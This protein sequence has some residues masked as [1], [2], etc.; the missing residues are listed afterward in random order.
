MKGSKHL[1]PTFLAAL[2]FLNAF[3]QLSVAQQAKRSKVKPFAGIP[4]HE[5]L[6]VIKNDY[7][8]SM[9]LVTDTQPFYLL[10][11]FNGDSYP[12]IAVLVNPEKSRAELKQHGVKYLDVDPS[13]PTNGKEQDLESAR[14][15]YCLGVAVIH[16]TAKGWRAAD[17]KGKYLFYECFIPFQLIPKATKIRRYYKGYKEAPPRLQGDAIYLDLEREGK[18]IIYWTGKTYRGYG[19]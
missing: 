14:F 17:P 16:G 7:G 10:G 5:I 1:P 3:G 19:Q 9:E 4:I 8:S 12:D 15:Q 18:A 2:L 13:S 11:D 6:S